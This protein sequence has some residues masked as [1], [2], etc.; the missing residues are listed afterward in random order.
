ME[1]RIRAAVPEL[2]D[3]RSKLVVATLRQYLVHYG[4]AQFLHAKHRLKGPNS[5]LLRTGGIKRGELLK[6]WHKFLSA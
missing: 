3:T 1:D 2:R 6:G 4:G 5:H